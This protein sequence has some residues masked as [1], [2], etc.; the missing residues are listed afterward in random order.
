VDAGAATPDEAGLRDEVVADD[1]SAQGDPPSSH[2][3]ADGTTQPDDE[4][5]CHELLE[6]GRRAAQA[7]PNEAPAEKEQDRPYAQ[8]ERVPA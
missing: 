1:E 5:A 6:V 3:H 8:S 7:R 4:A 2:D